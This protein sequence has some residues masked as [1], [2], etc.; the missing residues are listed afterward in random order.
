[1]LTHAHDLS[2]WPQPAA[3]AATAAHAGTPAAPVAAAGSAVATSS[4]VAAAIA[5]ATAT[6]AVATS[7]AITAAVFFSA[8]AAGSLRPDVRGAVQGMLQHAIVLGSAD[9]DYC[10]GLPAG[11]YEH[12]GVSQRRGRGARTW[13]LP[14]GLQ[15]QTQPTR[16]GRLRRLHV[17]SRR[18]TG[19]VLGARNWAALPIRVLI[20]GSDSTVIL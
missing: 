19:T 10:D 8:A 14:V 1:M 3:A 2:L 18:R 17:R 4:T 16:A 11:H 12:H 6:V 13:Q 15:R 20:Q 7:A 9:P 5:A